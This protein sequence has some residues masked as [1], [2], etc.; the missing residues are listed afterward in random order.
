MSHDGSIEY[1]E[2]KKRDLLSFEDV[3]V[4]GLGHFE[5]VTCLDEPALSQLRSLRQRG[6]WAVFSLLRTLGH[7]PINIYVGVSEDKA[8]GT[9]SEV[10]L[11]KS[12]YI[13]GVAT[14]QAMRNRGIAT[15]LLERIHEDAK[16]R[17]KAW[18]V[19]DVESHN[20]V[21]VSLYRKM[22]YEE[23]A[24]YSWH[25]GPLPEKA[26]GPG[27]TSMVERSQLDGVV[28]WVKGNTPS[29][30]AGPLPPSVRRFTHL[31]LLVRAPGSSEATWEAK[32]S[33]QTTCVVRSMYNSTVK[34]GYVIPVAQNPP[35]AKERLLE[36]IWSAVDWVQSLGG[37]RVAVVTPSPSPEWDWALAGIGLP[38]QASTTLMVRRSDPSGS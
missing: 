13:L 18:T 31:E 10:L 23:V 8:V 33:G 38:L 29:A 21:A 17:R 5:H 9:A 12:A 2:L 1:R 16:R 24:G 34:T 26:P 7:A 11:E 35:V 36:T 19:L 22:G 32:Q 15:R 25:V 20:E 30:V 37:S 3:M 4:Q 6:I 27:R 14:E 28:S